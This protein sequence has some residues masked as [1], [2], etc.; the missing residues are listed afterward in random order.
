MSW[1][2]PHTKTTTRFAPW[3]YHAHIVAPIELI[4][5]YEVKTLYLLKTTFPKKPAAPSSKPRSPALTAHR[6][7]TILRRTKTNRRH[8]PPQPKK[9]Q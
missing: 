8:R 1:H 9:Q 7:S 2:T 5:N 4:L 3:H 6:R